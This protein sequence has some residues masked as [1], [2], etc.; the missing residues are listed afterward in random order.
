MGY[1][2]TGKGDASLFS[3]LN[4]LDS[5]VT[6]TLSLSNRKETLAVMGTES[7]WDGVNDLRMGNVVS[8]N[9]AFVGL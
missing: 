6:S 9:T 5:G 4:T 2:Y 1:S 8:A 7:F 3:G